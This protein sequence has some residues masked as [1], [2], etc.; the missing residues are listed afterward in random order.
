MITRDTIYPL[1]MRMMARAITAIIPAGFL[2]FVIAAEA[3]SGK[4]T[5]NNLF[6]VAAVCAA[7]LALSEPLS[8]LH[9]KRQ[10]MKYLKHAGP[11][12]LQMVERGGARPVLQTPEAREFVTEKLGLPIE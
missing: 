11:L 7:V 1:T 6:S 4:E 9:A 2:G 5:N 12:I 8:D 3:I 10:F